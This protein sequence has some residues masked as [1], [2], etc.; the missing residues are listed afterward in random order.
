[1]LT[2]EQLDRAKAIKQEIL[3]HYGDELADTVTTALMISLVDLLVSSMRDQVTVAELTDKVCA[4]F[5]SELPIAYHSQFD[6][7]PSRRRDH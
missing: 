1:M 5:R 4:F 3:G 6:A 2:P 7:T